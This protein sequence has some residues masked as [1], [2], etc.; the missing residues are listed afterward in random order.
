MK[1]IADEG[2]PVVVIPIV[3]EPVQVGLAL[4]VVPPRIRNLP[5]ALER[6]VRNAIR[7]TTHRRLA[8]ISRLN[9]MWDHNPPASRTE[10]LR[11]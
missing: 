5:V 9:L 10:Y 1:R 6:I 7:T 3:V 11:F 4:G 2:E 8:P